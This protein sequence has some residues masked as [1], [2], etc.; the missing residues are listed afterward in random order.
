MFSA[1]QKN[2]IKYEIIHHTHT[3]THTHDQN[4]MWLQ[5]ERLSSFP[6]SCACLESSACWL[7][8]IG[9]KSDDIANTCSSVDLRKLWSRMASHGQIAFDEFGRPFIILKDQENQKRLTG[10]DAQKVNKSYILI[11]Q[12]V[13]NYQLYNL[14]CSCNYSVHLCNVV[15]YDKLNF[16]IHVLTCWQKHDYA[17]CHI[18]MAMLQ[19]NCR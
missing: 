17:C 5:L 14:L 19:I 11:I 1:Y 16:K 9:K 6:V 12:L 13:M 8:A 4:A 7:L 3:H 10:L 2:K 15:K 18:A